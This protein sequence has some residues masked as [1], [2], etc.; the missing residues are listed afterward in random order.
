M[1]T[2]PLPC[3]YLLSFRLVAII[4]SVLNNVQVFCAIAPVRLDDLTD[5]MQ[6]RHMLHFIIMVIQ[7]YWRNKPQTCMK[8][9]N[10][11]TEELDEEL[12]VESPDSI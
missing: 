1:A 7:P 3:S 6:I 12:V 4:T 8:T 9:H 11:F 5:E 2:R 10:D